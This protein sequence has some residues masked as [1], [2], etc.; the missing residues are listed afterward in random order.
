[1]GSPL[2]SGNHLARSPGVTPEA[3]CVTLECRPQTFR[4]APHPRVRWLDRRSDFDLAREA[5]QAS[6]IAIAPADWDDWRRQGFR[7]RGIVD[8][9]RLVASAAVWTCS[10]AAWELAAVHTRVGYRR[11]GHA[12]AV[13][14]FATA[15]ILAHVATA[16]CTTRADN[17][18]MLELAAAL[19][20]RRT[21]CFR[22][23]PD[24]PPHRSA[25]G[26]RTP[27]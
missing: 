15:H 14:S 25:P 11:R 16:T 19:G 2:A 10:P 20:F 5:W 17:T 13:C 22:R 7:Y 21:A 23:G 12:R 18:P 8:D 6:G 3:A 26:R 9:G 4:P 1:M 24:R 27:D